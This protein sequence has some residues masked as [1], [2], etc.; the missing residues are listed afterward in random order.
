MIFWSCMSKQVKSKK[1]EGKGQEDTD[2]P[3]LVLPL[4]HFERKSVQT[5][6]YID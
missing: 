6:C 3:L 1:K 4:P 5:K 2:E